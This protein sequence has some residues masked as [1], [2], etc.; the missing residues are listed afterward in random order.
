MAVECWIGGPGQIRTDNRH[1]AKVLLC[2]W[3][4]RPKIR[5]SHSAVRLDGGA[6][7]IEGLRSCC[8]AGSGNRTHTSFRT[9]G[10][11]PG[12]S[13]LFRHTGMCD[14]RVAL[15]L[16][17]TVSAPSDGAVTVGCRQ[18]ESNPHDLSVTAPSRRRVYLVPPH[19]HMVTCTFQ[20]ENT[21]GVPRTGFE[22][23]ASC[24]RSRRPKPSRPTGHEVAVEWCL[25]QVSILRPPAFQTGALPTELP[26]H[27]PY[28]TTAHLAVQYGWQGRQDSNLQPAVLETA[29]QPVELRPFDAI[30]AD[31]FH[32]VGS[33]PPQPRPVTDQLRWRSAL[34]ETLGNDSTHTSLDS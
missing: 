31:R 30:L 11:K 17:A 23:V 27:M 1:L 4:Y 20:P 3:S 16:D 18:R 14:L 6:S 28:W 26:R 34:H 29:A 33:P 2:R 7:N 12:A 15:Q 32:V 24:V 22:P 8:G 19:R 10:P 9:P 5:W 21:G 13:A 25:R